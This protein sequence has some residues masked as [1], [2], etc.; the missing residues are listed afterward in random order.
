MPCAQT[1]HA[2]TCTTPCP[3][4]ESRRLCL[5]NSRIIYQKQPHMYSPA[6]ASS[7]H[8]PFSCNGCHVNDVIHCLCPLSVCP[9]ILPVVGSQ[10]RICKQ[11]HLLT[12]NDQSK[13]AHL[14][15]F[16]C[17]CQFVTVGRE[18]HYQ[19]I[20]FMSLACV[21]RQFSSEIPEAHSAISTARG[22]KP[23]LCYVTQ[24]LKN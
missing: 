13:R 24:L 2:R 11:F 4:C 21:Q 5:A 16:A 23:V 20:R 22:K 17:T 19:N 7:L 14:T 18:L 10:I 12:E 15:I 3:R 6:L 9:I 1:I 8:S